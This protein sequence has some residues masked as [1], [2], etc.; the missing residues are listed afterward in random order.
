MARTNPI[1]ASATEKLNKTTVDR[2]VPA[3]K[4]FFVWD[5]EIKG[6]GVRVR[7]SGKRVYIYKYRSPDG[8]QRKYTIGN[9]GSITAEKARTV[10]RDIA[11]DVAHGKDPANERRVRKSAPTMDDLCGRYLTDHA[12][13][14]KKPNSAKNDERIIDTIVKPRLGKLKV[15][16]VSRDDIA[17]L[18]NNLRKTPY[19]A[20]RTLALISKM[21]NLAEV[22]GLRPDGSNPCRHVKKYKEEKRERFLTGDEL[23]SLSKALDKAEREQT[24]PASVILAIRLLLLTGCRLSEILTLRWNW[25]DLQAGCL[26][27][28][29][30][31][32]G[33]KIVQLGTPAQELLANAAKT[34]TVSDDNAPHPYV[35]AGRREGEHLVNLE[36]PWRRIRKIAKL[37]DVRIHDLRHTFASFGAAA[38]LSL[39]MI[40]KMLGHTQAQTTQRY[41][42]LAP[43]PVKE[44]TDIVARTISAA[45][46]G[47]TADIVPLHHSK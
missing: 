40:G 18:H 38:Q 12:N 42:H 31:K 6:F 41:A 17:K 30:S 9:H 27:L 28:P 25:V 46:D 11:Y 39:P 23:K 47:E 43:D 3:E 7:P 32:T 24:E 8:R 44:A 33:A 37:E 36:K 29:D 35:I 22:W 19:Q 1:Q 16:A 5:T 21:F 14:H 26:R 2:T 10:A 20:N 13:V 15:F 34:R 4:D 45:M